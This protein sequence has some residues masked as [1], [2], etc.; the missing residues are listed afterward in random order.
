M[1][2]A[3]KGAVKRRAAEKSS[4]GRGKT[5]KADTVRHPGI[6][7]WEWDLPAG[8]T[9]DGF[10]MAS[11]REVLDPSVPTR[12]LAQLSED[13]KFDLAAK[14]FEMSPEEVHIP[15]YGTLDK[16]R[17]AGEVRDRSRVGRHLADVQF[18]GIRRGMELGKAAHNKEGASD[19]GD[20]NRD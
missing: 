18:L 8:F 6:N 19:A 10:R 1:A 13:H 12:T 3:K 4:A 11:L 17:A 7:A 16:A 20:R 15:G 14:R 9:T 5:G 2:T